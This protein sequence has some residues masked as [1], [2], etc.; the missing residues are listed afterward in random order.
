MNFFTELRRRNVFKI[1]VAYAVVAWV[2]VQVVISIKSPLHLPDW[3]DTLT[4]V[5]LA[6]GFPIALI[7]TW[8]FELTPQ[9]IQTTGKTVIDP[10]HDPVLPA[11]AATPLPPASD[12]ADSGKSGIRKNSIA[13]LPFANM[14]S[15]PEQEYFADGITEELLNSLTQIKDLQ[16]TGRTSSF[17]FKGRNEDLRSI[18]AT[19]GVEYLLEGSVRKSTGRLRI[20]AQL[21]NTGTGHHLWSETYDRMMD[22]LFVIQEDI[23]RSVAEALEITLGVGGRGRIPGMTH[24]VAAYDA[25]LKAGVTKGLDVIVA[26]TPK[27]FREMI[28]HLEQAVTLDPDFGLAWTGLFTAYGHARTILQG[29]IPDGDAKAGKAFD[30]AIALTPDS[31]MLLL[32]I[33]VQNAEHGEWLEA[34]RYHQD[35]L[36]AAAR[37]GL[38]EH[39]NFRAGWF[40]HSIGYISQAIDYYEKVRVADPLHIDNTAWLMDAY[41]GLGDHAAAYAEVDRFKEIDDPQVSFIQSSALLVA[42]ATRDRAEVERRLAVFT[43][44][45]GD[46]L[47]ITPKMQALLDDP[48]AARVELHRLADSVKDRSPFTLNIIAVWADYFDAPEL[49]L[50]LIREFLVEQKVKRLTFLIWRSICSGTRRLPGFKDLLRD[51]GLVDFWRATGQWPDL[52]RPLG[53][54]D[55]E[56]R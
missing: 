55:F 38:S 13:V 25:F 31:P 27:R 19:L 24:N 46:L 9:G 15:D 44:N 45:E 1:A 54:D 6:V 28:Q 3:A 17:Y 56:C 7:I 37:Y 40:L 49:A 23:A 39:I 4:I 43:H 5:L 33:A 52:C 48:G 36:A 21:I 26:T 41:S 47:S 35:A 51:I 10:E 11:T 29:G 20:T 42:V 30:R 22:D 2:L 12:V 32:Q 16:V 53:E 18:G 50:D 14:S 34:Y 8:A